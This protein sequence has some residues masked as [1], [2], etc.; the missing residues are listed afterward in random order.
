M[1]EVID[2][3]VR[4]L[5]SL[6]EDAQRAVARAIMD[7]SASVRSAVQVMRRASFGAAH[8]PRS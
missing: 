4:V 2:D 7:Y 5:R 3:V 8:R 1:N 6:P